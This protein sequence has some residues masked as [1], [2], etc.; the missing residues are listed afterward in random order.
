LNNNEINSLYIHFPFCR[1]LCNYCDFY[2]NIP[3]DKDKEYSSFETSLVEGYEK[4]FEEFS[5][6]NY[7]LGALNTLYLGGGTPSLWGERGALFLQ[8]FLVERK[9]KLSSD[10]EFTLEVNPGG[11]TK[12]GLSKFREI[13]ANRFSLGIQSL[14]PNFIK[15]IDRIHNIDDVFETLNYF[16]DQKL[17]FSVD[18]MLGLPFSQ[19]YSRDIISELEEILSFEPEHISLYILTTKAGY[20]HK[21]HL[22]DDEYIEKEYLVVASFLKER[23]YLHYEVSNF[24]LPNK[25]SRH[26]LK[27]WESQSVMSLG[28]SATGFL[29][30]DGTRYKWKVSSNTFVKENLNNEE[31][32][33]EEIYMALRINRPIDLSK[34][35]ENTAELKIILENWSALGYL[36][37]Y[38]EFKISLNSKAFLIL[39]SLID[40]LFSKKLI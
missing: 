10:C 15:I 22:P 16:K 35:I 33:L 17:S 36:E 26:N 6:L 12:E 39:D 40:D 27:Y 29:K 28:A 18:F 8:N 14:N 20:I 25:E 31:L 32:K 21:D 5:D 34:Y 2:K 19:K 4:F 3:T 1:H 13:G 23:G 24:S 30:E 7:E 38:D 11:W 37:T 9:I